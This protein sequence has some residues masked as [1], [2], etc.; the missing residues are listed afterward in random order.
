MGVL[1]DKIKEFTWSSWSWSCSDKLSATNDTYFL[2]SVTKRLFGSQNSSWTHHFLRIFSNLHGLFPFL[3]SD[4]ADCDDLS[5]FSLPDTKLMGKTG[6]TL[7]LN[8][9]A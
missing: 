2:L 4:Y 9:L 6:L 7:F 8:N 3:T 5:F 1:V